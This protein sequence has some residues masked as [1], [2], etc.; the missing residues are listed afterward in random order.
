[1]N[2]NAIPRTI[3]GIDPMMKA[4]FDQN[5]ALINSLLTMN[6]RL[7]ERDII[8]SHESEYLVMPNCLNTLPEFDGRNDKQTAG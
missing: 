5:Q 7:Q 8:P 3:S 1:M 2:T 4:L 6:S